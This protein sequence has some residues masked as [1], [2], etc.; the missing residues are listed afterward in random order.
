MSLALRSQLGAREAAW[1]L[2]AALVAGGLLG[3]SDLLLV[4]LAAVG[5]VA[6]LVFGLAQPALF[7]VVFLFARPLLDDYSDNSAGAGLNIGGGL[8]ALVVVVAIGYALSTKKRLVT[9]RASYAA[10]IVLLLTV[11][12]SGWA[13]LNYHS[14]IGVRPVS[15]IVRLCALFSVYFL[16]VNLFGS[17][18]GA[19]RIVLIAALSAV[20]P[21]IAG[22]L[23]WIGGAPI[24]EN[25][26]LG[27]I[28]GPFVGPNAFGDYLA[29]GAIV[30]IALPRDW[31]SRT[32]RLAGIAVM[33]GALVGTYSRVGYILF[34][35]GVLALG[36]RVHRLAAM[37]VVLGAV[38]VV[39]TVP[40]VHD[41]VLP[42][43]SPTSSQ[44]QTYESFSWRLDNWRGLLRQWKRSPVAGYGIET[45]PFVN[46]RVTTVN[47][48][49]ASRFGG[50]FDAHNL[51]VKTLVEGGPLLL[52]AWAALIATF[53]G[54]SLRL[55]R[56]HWPLRNL[57]FAFSVLWVL[58]AIISVS[59]GEPTGESALMFS[60][61]AGTGALE[62]AH[63]RW[64]DE[65]R[66]LAVMPAPSPADRLPD[67]RR[68]L[69]PA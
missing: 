47:G 42:K 27:R 67:E 57:G 60:L 43:E 31:V 51:A 46:P 23:Q 65:R 29:F 9:P 52:L 26:D 61:L 14:A 18:R 4:P 10:L 6:M 69:V 63:R 17:L 12:F 30:L 36:W 48:H 56:D 50:G 2:A 24:K 35:G 11:A 19:R 22:V 38:A 34:L 20:L 16:A 1:T 45:V 39:L 25:V 64:R 15:E 8:G 41:R 21:A 3:F 33:A 13:F 58:I 7:V 62:G 49:A 5:A 37:S 32:V 66:M 40:T 54:I 53:I 55:A 28:S 59:T 44:E 68:E